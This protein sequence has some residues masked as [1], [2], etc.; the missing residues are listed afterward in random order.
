MLSFDSLEYERRLAAVKSFMEQNGVDALFVIDEPNICWLTGYLGYSAYVPQGML[1]TLAD[2]QPTLILR[3]MDVACAQASTWLSERNLLCY[4]ERLLG[5]SEQPVWLDVGRLIR[6]RTQSKRFALERGAWGLTVDNSAALLGALGLDK[7]PVDASGWLNRVRAVKSQ[8]E[9]RYIT[10]AASIVDDALA[11]GIDAVRVGVR[12]CDVAATILGKLA[13]G[14]AAAPGGSPRTSVT[15]PVGKI[16]NAPHLSWS[17]RSYERNSQTNFE[18]GAYRHRYCCALSRTV[19]LGAPSAR[20]RYIDEVV[21]DA[22][23]ATLPAIR[24]GA[25]C[26]EAYAAFWNRFSPTGV[27]KESRIGYGIG[28]DW[29]EGSY[30]LQRDDDRVLLENAT[31]HLIIGIWEREEGYVFS[32]TLRVTDSGAVSFSR[33]QRSMFVND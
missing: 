14:T 17:D 31:V 23:E 30:S 11:A 8:A 28:I 3:E 29:T 19:F 15:M 7:P 6:S 21:R 10:E 1:V 32:E 9:L 22:F 20:L 4:D 12:E 25:R 26:A 16:A 27:R 24:T 5:L 18:V 2:P 33:L 13:S